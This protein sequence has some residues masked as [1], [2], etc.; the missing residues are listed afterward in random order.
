M[1]KNVEQFKLACENCL[2]KSSVSVLRI[3]GRKLGVQAPCKKNKGE[4]VKD[5]IGVL[6]GEIAPNRTKRGAPIKNDTMPLQLLT[7]ID[8]LKNL[9]LNE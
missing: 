3:Y 6:C 4:L 1:E 5:I 2:L 9:Y 7:A 8:Q